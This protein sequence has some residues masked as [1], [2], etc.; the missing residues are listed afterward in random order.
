MRIFVS[1]ASEQHNLADELALSLRSRG[2]TVFFAGDDLPP[3]QSFEERLEKGVAQSDLLIFLI[4]PESITPGRYPLTELRF[5]RRKWPDPN[6]RILPVLVEPT[7]KNSIP[8]YLRAITIYQPEGNLIAEVGAQVS[9][10]SRR[11]GVGAFERPE[12]LGIR[13][14][15]WAVIAALLALPASMSLTSTD[16]PGFPGG[17][18]VVTFINLLALVVAYRLLISK[19]RKVIA[20]AMLVGGFWFLLL[21]ASYFLAA[22]IFTYSVPQEE[23]VRL[24]K[25][26]ECTPYASTVYPTTC[27]F[28]G[29]NELKDANYEAEFLWTKRSIS[30]MHLALIAVW[31]LAYTALSTLVAAL[32]A[33]SWTAGAKRS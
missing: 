11:E 24:I 10:L 20:A 21:G 27:P 25:G 30:M 9:E 8:A 22:S 33:S 7:N 19:S 31:I 12:K 5:A 18:L 16:P 6:G 28:L 32:L 13:T 17:A 14:A 29:L 23:S 3:A 4:S 15:E 26:F 1:F 2:H